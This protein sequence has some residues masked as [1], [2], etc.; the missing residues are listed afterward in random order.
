VCVCVCVDKLCMCI[1]II[2]YGFGFF[3]QA[4]LTNDN[5]TIDFLECY[6]EVVLQRNVESLFACGGMTL[7]L[8]S[9]YY[10]VFICAYI[11]LEFRI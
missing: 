1:I 8:Y 3:V 4:G 6:T 10:H 5:P 11:S 9:L 2:I 7:C